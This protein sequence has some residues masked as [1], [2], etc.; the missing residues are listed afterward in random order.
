[1]KTVLKVS[2]IIGM[3]LTKL[4]IASEPP[5][6]QKD[7]VYATVDGSDLKL[8]LIQPTNGEGPFPLIIWSHPGAWRMLDR[9][10]YHDAMKDFARSSY[11]SASVQYRFAPKYKHPAQLDDMRAAL[12]FLRKNATEYK[13]DPERIVLA[14]GSAGGQLS[15]LLGMMKVD[16]KSSGVKAVVNFN[17]PSDFRTWMAPQ[18]GDPLFRQG[19]KDELNMWI[20]DYLGTLDRDAKIMVEASPVTFIDK[21][22]PAVLTIHGTKDGTV[23]MS[24]SVQLHEVLKKAGVTEKLYAAKDEGHNFHDFAAM[25]EFLEKQLQQK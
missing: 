22:S 13:I 16:G 1:M 20:L 2:L 14:G 15:L 12:K 21:D 25:K 9:S 10:F 3:V 8:D 23:P 17:G 19:Y 7:I 6:I 5:K 4:A 18:E 11:V 24:Q